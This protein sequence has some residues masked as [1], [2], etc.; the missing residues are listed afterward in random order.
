M[1][2]EDHRTL[3]PCDRASG[4]RHVIGEGDGWVLN[5]GDL[6][7]LTPQGAVD[8]EP[9]R[10][11][12]ESTVNQNYV[13]RL[14]CSRHVPISISAA[15]CRATVEVSPLE[16]SVSGVFGPP[17]AKMGHEGSSAMLRQHI[18]DQSCAPVPGVRGAFTRTRLRTAQN[19]GRRM[20]GY[21]SK[22]FMHIEQ[23]RFKP[24]SVAD[25]AQ[26]YEQIIDAA[27][28]VLTYGF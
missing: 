15:R 5:D 26:G 11:V 19:A 18:L 21:S 22:D 24:L 17:I 9:P 1:A 3:E 27:P 8:A 28:A 25:L 23:K 14:T 4:H 6:M 16:Q 2:H 7:A 13:R 20:Y 10:T 12:N